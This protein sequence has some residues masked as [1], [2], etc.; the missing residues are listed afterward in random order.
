MDGD[1][2]DVFAGLATIGLL[3]RHGKEGFSADEAYAIAE[4]LIQY[5]EAEHEEGIAKLAKKTR[6]RNG[7]DT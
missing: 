4:Q 6:K 3:M 5:K 7:A 1:L 2:R